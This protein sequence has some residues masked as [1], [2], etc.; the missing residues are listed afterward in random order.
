MLGAT[1]AANPKVPHVI[2]PA[3]RHA[4]RAS[5]QVWLPVADGLH[6]PAPVPGGLPA[7]PASSA[8]RAA[9]RDVGTA[10]PAR[11]KWRSG[12]S[13]YAPAPDLPV[14]RPWRHLLLLRPPLPELLRPSRRRSVRILL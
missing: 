7:H 10:V 2:R 5:A 8:S 12:W 4:A 6:L 11:A 1:H 3:P 14:P 9:T 13:V